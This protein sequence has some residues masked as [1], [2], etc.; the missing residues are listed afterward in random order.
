MS[1]LKL[2]IITL[3]LLLNSNVYSENLDKGQKIIRIG[4]GSIFKGYYSIALDLCK[5]IK[6]SDNNTDCVVVPTKGG[7]E[8]LELLKNG[9]IDLALVQANVAVEAFEG[10]G[11]YENQEKMPGLRQILNLY[12]EFFTVIVKDEDKIKVFSDIEGKKISKGPVASG[13]SISY[14]AL[15]KFYKFTNEPINIDIDYENSVKEFCD[16]KIDAIIMM[17][18]HPNPLVALIANSC[19]VDFISI[20]NTKI[21]QLIESDKAF[22]RAIMYKNLYPGITADQNS[23]AVS[24]ILVT[25][26]NMDFK[27]LDKFIGMFHKTVKNFR[28]SNYMLNNIDITYFADTNNFVLPKHPAVRNRK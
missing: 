24:S 25:N 10:K 11:Y 23:F 20:E 12:D 19:E 16:G 5:T 4:S 21:T 28:H 2:L 1:N 17:I 22:H 9:A 3:L 8:N 18:G 26:E 6:A 14:N 27:S 7:E 13:S 15:R